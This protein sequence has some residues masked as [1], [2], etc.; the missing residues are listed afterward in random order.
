MKFEI[1]EEKD[2]IRIDKFLID[3][4][5]LSRSKVQEMIKQDL[6]LVNGKVTKN[7]YILR[8]SDLVEITGELKEETDVLPEKMKVWERMWNNQL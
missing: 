5:D 8:L 6:V 2:L 4:L 1:T 7:S 3:K